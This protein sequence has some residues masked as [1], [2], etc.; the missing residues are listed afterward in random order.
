MEMGIIVIQ[1]FLK[2]SAMDSVYKINPQLDIPIYQQ[3]VDAISTAIKNNTL[4]SGHQLPTVQEM[5]EKLRIARGTVK[6]AYDELELAGMIEKVQ[7]RGTF[8]SYQPINSGSRKERAM[9]AIDTMLNQLENMGLTPSE[10]SIFLNLKLRERSE[11]ESNVKV[12]AVE[13]NPENLS[14]MSEQLRHIDGVDLYSYM[15]ENVRQY[16]Y[17]LSES[18]DLI[19]TTSSHAQ[20]LEDI[21]SERKKIVRVALRPSA[22]CLSHII[23]LSPGKRIGIVG[24]SPRF[25]ELLY[26]TCK[27]YAENITLYE[28]HINSSD[29]NIESYLKGKDVILVPKSYEKHLT[30]RSVQA[31]GKF[32]GEIIDCYYEMDEGSILYL[33]T[34]IKR[35]LETKSI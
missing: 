22:R 25:G 35:L 1:H 12:V 28:P 10:V 3:L 27:T 20:Y 18:F 8:V 15:L 21:V 32:G 9:A 30:A 11:K 24:Y 6:R 17:K 14:Q 5:T 33:E 4:P 26:D 34:K 2:V 23:K 16:P 13:C 7:G 29:E 19:V 31:I